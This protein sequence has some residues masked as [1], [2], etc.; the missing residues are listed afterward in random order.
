MIRSRTIAV[1]KGRTPGA[2]AAKGVADLLFGRV[3][4]LH[5]AKNHRLL[6]V[7]PMGTNAQ[8]GIDIVWQADGGA[9]GADERLAGKRSGE[10]IIGTAAF[11]LNDARGFERQGGHGAPAPVDWPVLQGSQPFAIFHDSVDE[12]GV[13]G[14]AGAQHPAD[15][16]VFHGAR[17]RE[18]QP[19]AQ[20]EIT[21]H[22]LPEK[23]ALIVGAPDIDAAGGQCVSLPGRVITGRTGNG[24]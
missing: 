9:I 24:R 1:L 23:M 13:G 19:R 16:P 14:Q 12:G 10:N 11:E 6:E 7:G 17:G 3:N 21:G 15:F 22:F 8:A 5:V 18:I 20:N 2:G 4:D